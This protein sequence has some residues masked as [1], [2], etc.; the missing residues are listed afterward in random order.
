M[1]QIAVTLEQIQHRSQRKHTY[2]T[3]ISTTIGI[4]DS[5]TITPNGSGSIL[6]DTLSD[7]EYT[8]SE[9]VSAISAIIAAP[10]DVTINNTGND[11]Y[12]LDV[13]LQD[14]HTPL[15]IV[16]FTNKH[17]GTTTTAPLAK[18]ANVLSVASVGTAIV[19]DNLVVFDPISVRYS[20]FKIVAINTLDITLDS[21]NDT[22]FPIGSF[23]D[24][25]SSNLSVDGSVTPVV[26]GVR[27]P[28]G[29]PADIEL[30][31]DITRIIFK[32][33]A[34]T[35]VDL[36]KFGDLARLTNGLLLR[37]ENGDDFN[38]FNVKSNGEIAGIAYDWTPYISTNPNQGQDGFVSRLTWASQGKMGA[39]VRLPIG[40][41]LQLI[42]QDDLT[43]LAEL[44]VT[45]EGSLVLD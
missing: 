23:V 9:S 8:V 11:G 17:T 20:Q 16:E 38:I 13:T 27:N 14:Q 31:L 12:S 24:I 19:G 2:D 35:A 5:Y 32:C 15:V 30:T 4:G 28:S 42:V 33:K 37:S 44:V 45:A 6:L 3:P 29:A 7:T 21:L 39:V 1:A 18:D 34:D 22:L 26:F 41:D 10:E 25:G 43:D 40:D 36:A